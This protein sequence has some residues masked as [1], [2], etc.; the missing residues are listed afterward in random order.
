MIDAGKLRHSL[1]RNDFHLANLAARFRFAVE[2]QIA[3]NGVLDVLKCLFDIPPLRVTP[4]KLR[5]TDRHAF[6]MRQQRHMTFSLHQNN[7]TRYESERQLLAH[8]EGV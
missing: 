2:I 7:R 3:A 8:D 6:V 5:T 4:W 1:S